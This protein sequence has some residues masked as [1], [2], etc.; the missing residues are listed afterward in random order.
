MFYT[1]GSRLPAVTMLR[2]LAALGVCLMHFAGTLESDIIQNIARFGGY[3]VQVFFVI[4]GFI[5]PYS[6]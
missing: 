4:S 2:G 3:G 5:L 1:P 6:M